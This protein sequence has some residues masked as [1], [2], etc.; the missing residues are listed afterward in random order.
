MNAPGADEPVAALP[1]FTRGL[2]FHGDYAFIG[3]SQV[4]ESAVFSGL[5]ITEQAAERN[6]GI[7]VVDLRSGQTVAF[8]KFEDAL[9]EIFAVQVVPQVRFPELLNDDKAVLADSFVLPDAVLGDVPDSLR[10]PSLR[11]SCA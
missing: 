8:V 10:F 11:R 3:L 4:R 7:W 5:P 9:Q 1:G 2:S 6:C